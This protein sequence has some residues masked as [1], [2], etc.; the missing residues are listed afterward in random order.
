VSTSPLSFRW[1]D[2]FVE[3]IDAARGLVPRS[4]WV[5]GACERALQASPVPVIVDP[6][7]SGDAPAIQ[8][9]IDRASR[10]TANLPE[11]PV[12]WGPDAPERGSST[13]VM[14]ERQRKLNEGR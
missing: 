8:A 13:D 9:S 1:E 6:G 7:A 2:E 10:A 3:R 14:A 4:A 12:Q 11:E 5:R